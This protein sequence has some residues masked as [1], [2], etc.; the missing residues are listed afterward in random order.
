M[1]GV[2]DQDGLDRAIAA[3]E[4]QIIAMTGRNFL[5]LGRVQPASTLYVGYEIE[6]MPTGTARLDPLDHRVR[7]LDIST[8]QVTPVGESQQEQPCQVALGIMIPMLDTML[9]VVAVR[10]GRETN[11]T[12]ERLRTMMREAIASVVAAGLWTDI[13]LMLELHNA[14]IMRV[15]GHPLDDLVDKPI[16]AA[17]ID[18]LANILSP[19][20]AKAASTS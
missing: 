12:P 13:T 10:F 18:S 6:T 20:V 14:G 17:V 4:V 19:L 16:S 8:W 3:G 5:V 11:P 15:A 9:E 1:Q 2:F 7:L